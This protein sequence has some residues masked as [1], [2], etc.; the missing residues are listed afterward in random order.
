MRILAQYFVARY[1]GLFATALIATLILLATV[2]LVLN[3]DDLSS[4]SSG[5]ALKLQSGGSISTHSS[6]PFLWIVQFLWVRVASYYLSDLLP[7]ASF[8]AAFMTVAWAGRNMELVAMQ[9][10]GIR[11]S[12]IV[13]PVLGAALIVSLASA[14]LHETII[15]RA[16]QTWRAEVLDGQ[17]GFD[18]GRQAFWVHKGRTITNIARADV[19]SRMLFGVEIFERGTDGTISRVIRADHIYIDE[20]GLWRTDSAQIWS[21]DAVEPADPPVYSEGVQIALDMDRLSDEA[22]LGAEPGLLPL[23]ALARYLDTQD[24]V[25]SSEDRRL[26]NI[27]HE[28]LSRPFMVVFFALLA[29]PFAIRVEPGGGFARSSVGAIITVGFFFLVRSVGSTF[30]QQG[31]IPV[32]LAPWFAMSLFS[33]GAM[34]ALSRRGI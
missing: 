6:N 11:L 5:S 2:E 16:G 28:R 13:L 32:G 30:S 17:S 24:G 29:L 8:V 31:I 33:L 34:L 1:L 21:F 3:L 7:I 18:F 25:P 4:L 10:G 14:I 19:A 23:P 12:R 15:L 27:F 20:D 22:L 9:A 26:I